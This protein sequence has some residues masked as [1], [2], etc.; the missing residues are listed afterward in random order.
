MSSSQQNRGDAG[1]SVSSDEEADTVGFGETF[2]TSA[3]AMFGD[4]MHSANGMLVNGGLGAA[5]SKNNHG[6][7]ASAAQFASR[8]GVST[9]S[10]PSIAVGGMQSL[11]TPILTSSSFLQAAAAAASTVAA[12]LVSHAKSICQ[13]IGCG[14]DFAT[15]DMMVEHLMI[16][17]V[18]SRRNNHD[19]W[20]GFCGWTGCV[21]NGRAFTTRQKLVTHLRTHTGEKPYEC[22]INNCGKHFSRLDILTKHMRSHSGAKP[23]ACPVQ[24]CGKRFSEA[25]SLEHH[26]TSHT[27][28]DKPFVC[29]YPGCGRRYSDVASLYRHS[30]AHI[31]TAAAA[32]GRSPDGVMPFQQVVQVPS[33]THFIAHQGQAVGMFPSNVTLLTP[34][35][36]S[37]S[38]L[39]FLNSSGSSSNLGFVTTAPA[40]SMAQTPSSGSKTTTSFADMID[41]S[42][43]SLVQHQKP[44]VASQ[45]QQ[46]PQLQ[47][48]MQQQQQQQQ[49]QA[50]RPVMKMHSF[51][52]T[53]AVGTFSH[54]AFPSPLSMPATSPRDLYTKSPRPS[55]DVVYHPV[56]VMQVQPFQQQAQQQ[57]RPHLVPMAAAPHPLQPQFAYAPMPVYQTQVI[58]QQQ[59][60]MQQQPSQAQ[61]LQQNSVANAQQE[62]IA[63]YREAQ[64]T[65]SSPKRVRVSS[66]DSSSSGQ[67]QAV[68]IGKPV[69]QE[70]SDATMALLS[71]STSPNN[72]FWHDQ[73]PTYPA[74]ALTSASSQ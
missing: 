49:Q 34:S 53:E 74:E 35:S 41:M 69:V 54:S 30:E 38:S 65:H 70:A 18:K 71:L 26:S 48:Q 21:R 19:N 14:L 3:N 62:H 63:Q 29:V 55:Q 50:P 64:E 25:K 2:A 51:P 60:V 9:S 1:S 59:F 32:M 17:H 5:G 23:F 42:Y 15:L 45:M 28:A 40:P 43:P 6:Q 16:E 44:M 56:Q 46:Q 10:P 36:N 68:P 27:A 33:Q 58:P 12:G 39:G 52:T 7:F 31:S 72:L 20:D 61:Q 22:T 47:M 37:A 13:W 8:G 11:S 57:T 24:G 73:S 4:V 67:T 66:S